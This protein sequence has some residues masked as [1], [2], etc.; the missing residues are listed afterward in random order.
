MC[1]WLKLKSN[2]TNNYEAGETAPTSVRPRN[3]KWE[4]GKGA[5]V[6]FWPSL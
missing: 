5:E 6:G 4:Q 3:A 1:P 2:E